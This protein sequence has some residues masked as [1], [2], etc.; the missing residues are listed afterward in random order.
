MNFI[1]GNDGGAGAS[2]QSS[3]EQPTTNSITPETDA[4]I[5]VGSKT[6]RFRDGSFVTTTVRIDRI[7]MSGVNPS[8]AKGD[9]SVGDVVELDTDESIDAGALVV[10]TVDGSGEVKC[11]NMDSD[12]TPQHLFVGVA[13][14][15]TLSSG[16]VQIMRRG[17]TTS[18]FDTQYMDPS[19]TGEVRLDDSTNTGVYSVGTTPINFRDSGGADSSYANDEYYQIFF[20]AVEGATINLQ[21]NTFE[22]EHTN[23]AAVRRLI[24]ADYAAE[25]AQTQPSDEKQFQLEFGTYGTS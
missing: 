1:N 24:D 3:P 7:D 21:F 10:Y 2:D 9:V 22:F 25:R 13:I 20:Q 8:S 12:T 15:D 14:G 16:V 17:L 19:T 5:D 18:V 11:R 4:T 6:K 23:K